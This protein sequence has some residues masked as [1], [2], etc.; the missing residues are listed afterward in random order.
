MNLE[1]SSLLLLLIAI[2]T[3]ALRYTAEMNIETF[4]QVA[5]LIEE[6]TYMD[7]VVKSVDTLSEAFTLIAD[8]ETVLREGNFHIK[9]WM[10]SS[11][12]PHLEDINILDVNNAR[13]LGLQ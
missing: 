11:G 6:N 7:D 10:V 13:V 9:H 4:P 2:A 1:H 12:G 3:M 5:K 8:T